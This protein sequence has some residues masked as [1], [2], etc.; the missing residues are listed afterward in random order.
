MALSYYPISYRSITIL[1]VYDRATSGRQGTGCTDM[2]VVCAWCS[3][4]IEGNPNDLEISHGICN[5]CETKFN[6]E[7][8]R[9]RLGT[10][11]KGADL[12][13]KEPT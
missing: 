3:N 8:D 12:L 6:K 9:L 1:A 7:L 11:S 2:K 13:K 5:P 10:T 4:H